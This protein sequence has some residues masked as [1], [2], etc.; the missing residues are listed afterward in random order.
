MLVNEV[1]IKGFD[2]NKV[3]KALEAMGVE[4]IKW[5]KRDSYYNK[6]VYVG[7]KKKTQAEKYNEEADEE[8]DDE[9]D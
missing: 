8:L 3:C 9:D 7:I 1:E 2:K 4:K 6:M 5:R